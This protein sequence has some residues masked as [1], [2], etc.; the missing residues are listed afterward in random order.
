MEEILKNLKKNWWLLPVFIIITLLLRC[1]LK[2]FT[3]IEESDINIFLSI[4]GVFFTYFGFIAAN[5]AQRKSDEIQTKSQEIQNNLIEFGLMNNPK[6]SFEDIFNQDIIPNLITA[7]QYS[8]SKI[9]MLLSSPAYGYPVVENS[10]YHKFIN[11]LFSLGTDST[12][13]LMVFSPDAHFDYWS[14]VLLW[15][16][17]SENKIATDFAKEII[18]TLKNISVRNNYNLFLKKEISIRLYG[19]DFGNYLTI[20]KNN[21]N[22][23]IADKVFLC[24]VDPFNIILS[25]KEIS[26]ARHIQLPTRTINDYIGIGSDSLFERFK[27][28]PYTMNKNTAKVKKENIPLLIIDFVFGLTSPGKIV[29]IKWFETEFRYFFD[30]YKITKKVSQD[31]EIVH[32]KIIIKNL[33]EYYK[34]LIIFFDEQ[35][36]KKIKELSDSIPHIFQI[37]KSILIVTD[38]FN[39]I[40][41]LNKIEIA[42]N[43]FYCET[44]KKLSEK[45]N[46]ITDEKDKLIHMIYFLLYGGLGK[47][48]YFEDII[49][50]KEN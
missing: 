5:F 43:E 34:E 35:H 7:K 8:D 10:T 26:K 22:K 42:S 23:S 19:F 36:I 6:E 27:I 49:N 47:S 21:E 13:E 2:K 30:N 38:E 31:N 16:T 48:L 32:L 28:C 25:Q 29:E 3:S 1:L 12:I 4:V 15:D 11:E 39:D 14:N 45:L 50:N 41:D 17:S 24:M 44:N 46:E 37:I 33:L 40:K 18:V 20:K 9:Y